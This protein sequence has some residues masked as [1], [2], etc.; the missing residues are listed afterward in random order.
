MH[1][2][3]VPGIEIAGETGKLPLPAGAGRILLRSIG[4][5]QFYGFVN[6]FDTGLTQ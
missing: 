4:K 6:I 2:L 5:R 3:R 1:L